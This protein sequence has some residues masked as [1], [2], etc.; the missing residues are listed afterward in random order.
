MSKGKASVVIPDGGVFRT[1]FEAKLQL[2]NFLKISA[3]IEVTERH[4]LRY[5]GIAVVLY[6]CCTATI[7]QATAAA[8][9]ALPV[10]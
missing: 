7:V 4:K 6:D 5:H 10:P 1:M 2:K 9:T 8:G 3:R